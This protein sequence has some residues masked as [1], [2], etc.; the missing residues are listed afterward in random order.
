M[1]KYKLTC[2]KKQTIV[3]NIFRSPTVRM[4]FKSG[5]HKGQMTVALGEIETHA[6]FYKGRCY[7]KMTHLKRT[8]LSWEP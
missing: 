8:D 3:N 5:P 1:G 4:S 7:K 2:G 6:R